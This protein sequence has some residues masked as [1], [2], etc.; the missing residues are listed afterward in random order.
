L[1]GLK[2]ICEDKAVISFGKVKRMRVTRETS[3]SVRWDMMCKSKELGGLWHTRS[4]SLRE[5]PTSKMVLYHW[6]DDEGPWIGYAIPCNDEDL[7]L[8]QAS[9]SIKLGNREK[10][11][12]INRLTGLLLLA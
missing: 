4:K 1:K 11:N 8:F 12:M 6:T 3:P 10:V 2:L 7:A 9:T 5:S